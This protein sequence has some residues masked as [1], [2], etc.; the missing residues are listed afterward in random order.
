MPQTAPREARISTQPAPKKKPGSPARISSSEHA[1]PQ[2][3]DQGAL[4]RALVD[5]GADAVL[6][7]T[8][9]EETKFMVSES[10]AAQ[11][12]PILVEMRQLFREQGQV[13]TEHSRVL[14]EHSRVLAEHSRVL[15]EHGRVLAEQGQRLESLGA[16]VQG[17]KETV[18]VKLDALKTEIRLIWGALGVL[19]TVL[20]VVFGFLFTN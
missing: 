16:D 7:Y 14:A 20:I 1:P 17:L 8:G 3:G 13:L 15:A 9:T 10:V 4:F 2:P 11:V 19:V 12:Q 18:D 6:A 5:A